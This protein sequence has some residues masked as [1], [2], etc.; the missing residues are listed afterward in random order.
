MRRRA[1]AAL[2]FALA[3]PLSV[4]ADHR[5][6]I[7]A[8]GETV[9]VDKS[10]AIE[11]EERLTPRFTGVW[12]GIYRTIPIQYRTPQGLNYTLRL[13]LESVTDDAGTPLKYET[14]HQRQY[15]KIKIW[16]PGAADA[17][18]NVTIRYR[19]ANA[20]R[21][22]DDHD[23]LY[24]NVTG[25]EWDVPIESTT[26]TIRLPEGVTGVRATAFR[27]AY[28]STQQN[29]V[30][31]DANTVSISTGSLGMHEGLTAVVGWDPGSVHRPTR[32]ERLASFIYSNLPLTI[33]LLVFAGMFSLW[34]SKGRDPDQAPIVTQYE[35][36]KE[37][38]PSELG[39]LV[40]AS[41]DMRDITA[42]IVD[43]AVRGYLHIDELKSEHLGGLFSD[44][45][46]RFTLKK[47]R[48][49]WTD[50]KK[51]ER[52]LLEALFGISDT[53][54]LSD[55]KNKFYKN[56]PGIKED[57]YNGLVDGGFYMARPDRVRAVYIIIAFVIAWS[58]AFFG[59]K[60]V[61]DM[62]MQALPTL[63]AGI[64]SG[65]I[66]FG[67]GWFMPCRTTKGARELEQ[68]LGFQEF[69]S[70][71]DADR[72]QRMIKTPDVFEKFLPYAMALGVESHWAKQFEGIAT[73]P[74]QWYTGYGPTPGFNTMMFTNNLSRM[75]TAASHTMASAPR[76][77]GGSGFGG[78]GSSGGGFGGGGGGGF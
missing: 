26:A 25:D 61:Q 76:S 36:P 5:L 19:I 9:T 7:A 39:T 17:E 46:Y 70:R 37:M 23:E 54:L 15:L 2:A 38:T 27:G 42:A 20:L 18:R 3:I 58:I 62:G 57:L 75:S 65:A 10:G 6:V 8:F 69:L 68:I 40:D 41:P 24:W 28:G 34:R 50:L 22:F 51:H 78:G 1:L 44:T 73:N 35:P 60:L 31:I 49:G 48:S 21:F 77:S 11:V 30:S 64:F 45:D 72:M 56:L 63:L 59:G 13:D 14:S 33:P 55:L 32:L 52:D 66:V 43:L 71:V 4:S 29:D 74:P 67:F 53:V 47:D 16:V 12:N